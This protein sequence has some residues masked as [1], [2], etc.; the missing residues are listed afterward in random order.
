MPAGEAKASEGPGSV[1]PPAR[2]CIIFFS[3]MAEL[4]AKAPTSTFS[5]MVS[6]IKAHVPIVVV[7]GFRSVKP[8]ATPVKKT[9]LSLSSGTKMLGMGPNSSSASS[10]AVLDSV[11][12]Q[13]LDPQMVN[14]FFP[15]QLA[16]DKPA[17]PAEA[18]QWDAMIEADGPQI[19][20][21]RNVR[22][23][24]AGLHVTN[25]FV[26]EQ[27]AAELLG[28]GLGAC[29]DSLMLAA[30]M[31]GVLCCLHVWN[32]HPLVQATSF[33]MDTLARLVLGACSFEAVATGT[34]Q[35]PPPPTSTPP[36]TAEAPAEPKKAE[37]PTGAL[38]IKAASKLVRPGHGLAIQ[39]SLSSDRK[40][41]FCSSTGD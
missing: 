15:T 7:A 28:Y 18:K 13:G 29:L 35:L 17:D 37:L 24:R 9:T 34:A 20:A 12:A 36:A 19:R 4:L 32:R 26:S 33:R 3:E 27:T 2:P 38:G 1:V 25:A 22:R 30:Y 31:T 6:E 10:Y 11:S 16:M 21:R 23:L 40:S 5:A 39:H 41:S 14:N 8:P